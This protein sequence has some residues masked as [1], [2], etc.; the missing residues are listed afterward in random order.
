MKSAAPFACR[1]IEDEKRRAVREE[2][3]FIFVERKFPTCAPPAQ[4][5]FSRRESQAFLHKVARETHDALWHILA[6][7]S[8]QICAFCVMSYRVCVSFLKSP[9]TKGTHLPWRAVPGKYTKE[10]FLTI[11]RHFPLRDLCVLYV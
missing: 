3:A 9:N 6:G 5:K 4:I 2:R 1:A 11:L 10:E 7:M 8:R